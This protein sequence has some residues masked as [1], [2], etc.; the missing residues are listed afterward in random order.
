MRKNEFLT[1]LR[2]GLSGRV[3]LAELEDILYDY[4]EI[5]AEGL[6]EGKA[7]EEI[8]S[9]LGSPARTVQSIMAE[10]HVPH[11]LPHPETQ[12]FQYASLSQ[13]LIAGIIDYTL[14]AFPLAFFGALRILPFMFLWPPLPFFY[15]VDTP[16]TP[17]MAAGAILCTC[18]FVLYHPFFLS[19]WQGRTPG[20]W[21]L[22]MRVVNRDGTPL[23][24]FQPFERELF[25]RIL[26][27][28]FTLGLSHIVSFF[29]CLFSREHLT[30]HDAMAKTRV[31]LS[32]P[33]LSE[34]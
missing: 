33:K 21:L 24:K 20:K 12:T 9:E 23:G 28:S 22:R 26:V 34:K 18:Y 19:V 2:E 3:S 1:E 10:R 27:S 30:I 7:E 8:C 13:R 25:G 17:G 11:S 32:A 6:N 16:P 31:I 29:W 4:N 15:V 5:F 14:A